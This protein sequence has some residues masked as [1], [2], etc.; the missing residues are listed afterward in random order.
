[1]K[2]KI[3]KSAVAA[4]LVIIALAL[5]GQPVHAAYFLYTNPDRASY[6]P[7]DSGTLTIVV[8]NT[9]TTTI[10]LTNLTVY[11]PWAGFGP[12]GKWQ[13]NQSTTYSNQLIGSSGT[14]S[15]IFTTTFQFTIPSWYGGG[16][17]QNC[18]GGSST[19]RY[20]QYVNCVVVG[21]N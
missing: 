18:F 4:T 9:G 21:S 13:G 5:I 17:I 15:S 6:V 11:F 8:S 16:G 12:D 1:M 3:G 10:N 20:G 2:Q 14:S 19:T 7:G